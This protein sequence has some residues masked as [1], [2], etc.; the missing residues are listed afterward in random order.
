[1]AL[2]ISRAKRGKN[3]LMLTNLDKKIKLVAMPR[4]FQFTRPW[5]MLQKLI[6]TMFQV[7]ISNTQAVI[8]A[9]MIWSMFMNAGIISLIYPFLVFGYA[10]LEETRPRKE[11]WAFVRE[12][13]VV[14]LF[15]KFIV[16]LSV[17][18]AFLGTEEF[19]QASLTFKLGL[20]NY[21]GFWLI[22]AYMSPEVLIIAFIMLNDIQLRLLGLYYY[23]E[24]DIE[25]IEDGIQRNIERGDAG[26]VAEKKVIRAN[27][28][29]SRL[30][31][32]LEAQIRNEIEARE[33]HRRLLEEERKEKARELGITVAEASS[34]SESEE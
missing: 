20:Y 16:N 10:L 24:E 27:M 7:V 1:M 2:L 17:L 29:L 9:A 11:F 4:T 26:R 34:E 22:C 25:T 3:L 33:E 6:E 30:F 12:Y 13:T 18:D 14:I 21:E 28:L 19:K 32:P 15:M 23:I 5:S 8:Y 31:L